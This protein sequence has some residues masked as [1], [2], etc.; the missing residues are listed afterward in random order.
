MLDGG[1]WAHLLAEAQHSR[2]L[3]M[4]RFCARIVGAGKGEA[5]WLRK[6]IISDCRALM[7]RGNRWRKKTKIFLDSR[8]YFEDD[9]NTPAPRNSWCGCRRATKVAAGQPNK[10]P[11]T[12]L[13]WPVTIA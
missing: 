7:N 1:E 8:R 5:N 6:E 12:G 10:N 9:E 3:G 2:A 11:A 4:V 13:I